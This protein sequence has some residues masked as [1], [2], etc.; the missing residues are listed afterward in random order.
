[1]VFVF[2]PIPFLVAGAWLADLRSQ[3]LAAAIAV[4]LVAA[5]AAVFLAAPVHP[6]AFPSKD[7]PGRRAIVANDR[8]FRERFTVLERAFPPSD[9][10]VVAGDWRWVEY[11]EPDYVLLRLGAADD[12]S[13]EGRPSGWP[14]DGRVS[15]TI[16][17]GPPAQAPVTPQGPGY[18]GRAVDLVLFDQAA[19]DLID[20]AVPR[21]TVALPTS[22]EVQVVELQPGTLLRYDPPPV[23]KVIVR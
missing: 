9:S 5:D 14:G 19:Q 7:L 2:L 4:V 16:L 8:F 18:G 17:L 22:G 3:R 21:T 11:Y 10:A 23:V 12:P 15:G 6:P 1:M 13:G 20:P